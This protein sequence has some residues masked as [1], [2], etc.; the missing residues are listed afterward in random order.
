MQIIKGKHKCFCCGDVIEWQIE[1][2]APGYRSRFTPV[3]YPSGVAMASALFVG[4]NDLLVTAQCNKCGNANQ[5][6]DT[7]S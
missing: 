2:R 3:E 5:F 4:E 7:L 1:V 6:K